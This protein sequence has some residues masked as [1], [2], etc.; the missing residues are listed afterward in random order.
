MR[1]RFIIA[2]TLALVMVACGDDDA[3][4]S[5]T[6]S[7][8]TLDCP[9][10]VAVA[11]TEDLVAALAALQWRG[12]GNYTSGCLPITPD[13]IVSGT[14]VLEAKD[15]PVP[16]DCLDQSDCRPEATLALVQAIPGVTLEGDANLDCGGGFTR[17]TLTDTTVRLRPMLRDTHPCRYNFVPLV[18]VHPPC[19]TPCGDGLALCP[20]DGVCYATGTSFC[21]A[22]EGGTKEACAC[23]GPDGPLADESPC[24]YWVSGDVRCDGVCRQGVCAA[25]PC[26]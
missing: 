26:P 11:S 25:G 20:V 8:P 17:L 24:S 9:D 2:L 15:L 7:V 6:T 22:C 18:E 19:G 12:E 4:I 5:T 13:L 23:R 10:A 16:A 14:V 21:Q 1:A 3:A